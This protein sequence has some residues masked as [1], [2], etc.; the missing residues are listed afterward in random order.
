[1][2]RRMAP[3]GGSA[4]SRSSVGR[5]S[6]RQPGASQRVRGRR[7]R[8]GGERFELGGELFIESCEQLLRAAQV[9]VSADAGV[10]R[11]GA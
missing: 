5:P 1:M 6:V 11:E 4:L 7:M 2:Q 3:S 8:V 9:N 10:E